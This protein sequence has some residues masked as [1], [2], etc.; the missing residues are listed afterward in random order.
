MSSVFHLNSSARHIIPTVLILIFSAYVAGQTTSFNQP[1]NPAP[2][3]VERRIERA[4]ALAAAHQL[5][6]AAT[7]LENVRATVNDLAIRN[8]TS[9]MLLGIY[10]EEGNYG[11]AQSLL[12]DSFQTRAAQKDDSIRTYFAMAGQAINGV[13]SHLARYRSYGLNTGEAGLP[14]EA[15]TDLDRV[16][17]FLERLIAQARIITKED[18]RLYDGL[19]LQEDVLGIRLSVPR[20]ANDRDKWQTEYVAAREQL[21]SSQI[22][23]ASLGRQPAL[24]AVAAKLPNPFATPTPATQPDASPA[25]NNAAPAGSNNS[26]A[27]AAGPNPTTT[28]TSPPQPEAAEPKLVSAGTLSGRETK[29]VTPQYPAQAKTNGVAG[30]VRVFAIVDEKGKVWVTGS[31]G[32]VLLR[33]AAEEAARNWIFPPSVFAGKPVRIAG[34]IDFEFKL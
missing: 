24:A 12:E 2:N 26:A 25:T 3:P 19:A 23:V 28:Q 34:Y 5:Q 11:R 18:G 31:E 6:A 20:D 17:N 8:G 1:E 22:Q 16:R 33:T 15:T 32:P 29:R 27:P 7:E 30:V 10:L 9:L 14:P 21:A 13:R 4:K